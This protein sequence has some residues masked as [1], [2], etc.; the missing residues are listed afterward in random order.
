MGRDD[1]DGLALAVQ[2]ADGADGDLFALVGGR[3]AAHGRVGAVA[4]LGGMVGG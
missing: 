3:C 2:G 1:G 4:E